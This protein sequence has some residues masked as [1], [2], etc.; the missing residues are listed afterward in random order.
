MNMKKTKSSKK[1]VLKITMSMTHTRCHS[2]SNITNSL[3]DTAAV[4]L[5]ALVEAVI[6]MLYPFL[7]SRIPI[8][9]NQKNWVS[10]VDKSRPQKNPSMKQSM[11]RAL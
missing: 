2:C 5:I 4:C 11:A 10:L 9:I 1:I 6:G 8:L 7:P 3:V